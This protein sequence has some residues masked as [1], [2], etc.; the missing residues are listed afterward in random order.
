MENKR[1][2]FFLGSV[3]IFAYYII[4]YELERTRFLSFITL[5]TI[6]FLIGY[7]LWK[8]PRFNLRHLVIL[9]LMLRLVF[10]LS[11]PKFSDDYY[12]FIWDGKLI[13]QGISPY[14]LTP[15]QLLDDEA[16]KDI[17]PRGIYH[18]LNSKQYH[19]V[20]PPVNQVFFS[21]GAIPGSVDSSVYLLRLIIL[22][23][24]IMNMFLILRLLQEFKLPQKNVLLYALNPLVIIELSGNLHFEGVMMFFFGAA[25]LLLIKG[26]FLNSSLFYFLASG[27]KL[28]PIMFL[29]LLGRLKNLKFA[30]IYGAIVV[31]LFLLS[32][33]PFMGTYILSNFSDSMDLYFQKFEFNAS[34]YYLFSH[35]IGYFAGFNPVHYLGPALMVVFGIIYVVI[36]LR[37]D[38]NNYHAWIK[39]A[40]LILTSYYLLST[41]VHPW[42]IINLV[43]IGI[44]CGYEFLI[45]WSLF[46]ALSYIYYSPAS[47]ELYYV[48]I[49][50]EY[51]V[52][53]TCMVR[54]L[55]YKKKLLQRAWF[56]S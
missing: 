22:I 32:F 23:F 2:L 40:A 15:S 1:A 46:A 33:L 4:G 11:T 8:K 24:E 38:K 6:V 48:L 44:I 16:S 41:T 27:I 18:R 14:K 54:E 35:T 53:I 56:S 49:T 37:T 36:L 29:P 34:I 43:F 47:L 25:F 50:V 20:Y 51:L 7:Y 19:S 39:S 26:K 45:I 42:Y 31:G 12:R 13:N 55:V 5:Y 9:G 30:F 17:I 52:V 3:S 10:F 21:I 28:I